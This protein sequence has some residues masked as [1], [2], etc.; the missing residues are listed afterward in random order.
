MSYIFISYSHFDLNTIEHLV[1]DLKQKGLDVWY[2]QKGIPPASIWLEEIIRGITRCEQFVVCLS[3][4]AIESEPVRREIWLA[5]G[6]RKLIIPI[7]IKPCFELLIKYEET[8]WIR[9]QLQVINFVPDYASGFERLYDTVINQN[10]DDNVTIFPVSDGGRFHQYV[11]DAARNASRFIMIGTGLNIL[12]RE[13]FTQELMERAAE[14]KLH[15]EI[16]LGDPTSPNVEVR[17][18]EEEMGHT[19]PLIGAQGISKRVEMLLN[20]AERLNYPPNIRIGFF[21]HYPSFALMIVDDDYLVY[22]YGY[23]TLGNFSPVLKF[24]RK[25][26]THQ[27]MIGFLDNQYKLIQA[28]AVDAKHHKL[29]NSNIDVKDL[30]VVAVY[31]VPD[32]CSDFYS[33]GSSVLGYNI[34]QQKEIDSEF[35]HHV[36]TAA[37]YGFHLTLSDALYVYN[38]VDKNFILAQLDYLS[39]QFMPFTLT[40]LTIRKSFPAAKAI[41]LSFDDLSGSLEALHFE[42][43]HRVNR[44]AVASNYSLGIVKHNR[45]SSPER[46]Q[47]MINRYNAPYI[48]QEFKPHFTLMPHAPTTEHD[49]LLAKLTEKFKAQVKSDEIRVDKLALMVKKPGSEYWQIE[50]EFKLRR[51]TS[52]R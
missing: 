1:F 18:I 30:T 17:L 7:M 36:G 2:D 48:L 14:G 24:S 21:R 41:S 5:K 12:N 34:R 38:D 4:E 42:L 26:L 9:D 43:T 35:K 25:V 50:K 8:R 22:P 27:A 33:F 49:S 11:E 20:A 47:Q 44:Y 32:E 46:S 52:V 40:N 16:Y 19:R 15:L 29:T 13:P 39:R 10:D 28:A 51:D 6:L 37:Q 31:F 45:N 23:T 3:P